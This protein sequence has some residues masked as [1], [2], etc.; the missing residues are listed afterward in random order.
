MNKLF[1]FISSLTILFIILNQA[2]TFQETNALL[3]CDT[4][5]EYCLE[6]PD[7]SGTTTT[8]VDS[9][10][11][12]WVPTSIYDSNIE[13]TKSFLDG[14]KFNN[15][16]KKQ[17]DIFEIGDQYAI[18]YRNFHKKSDS[19]AD[20]GSGWVRTGYDMVSYLPSNYVGMTNAYISSYAPYTSHQKDLY[21]VVYTTDWW[22]VYEIF[23]ECKGYEVVRKEWTISDDYLYIRRSSANQTDTNE[24]YIPIS[25]LGTK[26]DDIQENLTEDQVNSFKH[27][28]Y[29]IS[30]GSSIGIELVIAGALDISPYLAILLLDDAIMQGIILKEINDLDDMIYNAI[31]GESI[32]YI[33]QSMNCYDDGCGHW[34]STYDTISLSSVTLYVGEDNYGNYIFAK[35]I[36]ISLATIDNVEDMLGTSN[37][38]SYID[39]IIDLLTNQ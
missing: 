14:Y 39:S 24:F 16:K 15:L 31:Q 11:D 5:P 19:C 20:L 23:D 1:I 7:P 17:S 33:N 35:E 25:A 12:P 3:G 26:L 36:E 28:L 18:P 37:S 6:G 13:P 32:L 38:E 9:R 4:S 8:Y 10:P 27:I 34:H 2:G 30:F 22:K 29:G 21:Y